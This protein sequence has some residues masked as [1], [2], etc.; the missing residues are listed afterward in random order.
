MNL[1][2]LSV[3]L[4]ALVLCNCS[5]FCNTLENAIKTGASVQVLI[6]DTCE[7]IAPLSPVAQVICVGE[8]AGYAFTAKIAADTYAQFCTPPAPGATAPKAP[9]TAAEFDAYFEAHGAKK[10]Q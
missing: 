10:A 6:A 2:R 1:I 5:A 4:F 7:C 8:A 9:Q 3:L